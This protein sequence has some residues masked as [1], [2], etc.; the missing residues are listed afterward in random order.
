M[1]IHNKFSLH[2]QA[3]EAIKKGFKDKNVRVGH[4]YSLIL[5]ALRIL[6]SVDDKDEFKKEIL[7][8]ANVIE[9]PKVNY[10]LL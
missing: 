10:I 3:L 7:D 1:Y 5:R 8:A 2:S 9:A 6:K 4:R